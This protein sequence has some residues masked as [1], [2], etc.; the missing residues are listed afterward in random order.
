MD[1]G[2]IGIACQKTS[3]AQVMAEAGFGDILIPYNVLGQP[4]LQRLT[5]LARRVKMSVAADSAHTVH[6]YTAAAAQAG[7]ELPVL[8]EFDTGAGRCI[9]AAAGSQ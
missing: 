7:I 8:V 9:E 1:A 6:G 2:A 3:E 4:K 5:D